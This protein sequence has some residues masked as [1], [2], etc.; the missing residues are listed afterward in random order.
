[1]CTT[2]APLELRSSDDEANLVHSHDRALLRTL[3]ELALLR[4]LRV[5]RLFVANLQ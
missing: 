4:G 3:F 2:A 5:S 1:M